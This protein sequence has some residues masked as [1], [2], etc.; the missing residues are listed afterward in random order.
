MADQSYIGKGP[1]YIKVKSAAGG[2]L[3]I[4]NCSAFEVGF[5][6]ESKELRDFTNIGGGNANVLKAVSSVTGKLTI[7]DYSPANLALAL[8]GAVTEVAAGAVADEAHS[9]SGID[10][11]FIPF[12]YPAD[13][14]EAVTVTTTAD[15]ALVEGTDYALLRSGITVIGTGAIDATGIKISYTKAASETLEALVT[16]GLEYEAHFHGANEAQQGT[17]VMVRLHRIKFSPAQALAFISDDFAEIAV[18]FELLS[19]ASITG[20][21]L[22]KFMRVQAV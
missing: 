7:H 3:P 11:E 14:A 12:D 18:E 4:G 13:P 9:T 10:G 21:G 17:E 20:S 19:D 8:R 6:E 1:L 16:A 5:E 22:S 15:G 2:F